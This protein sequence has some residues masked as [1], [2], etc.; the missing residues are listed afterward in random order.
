M[1]KGKKQL[2]FT[3]A[4]LVATVF[5]ISSCGNAEEEVKEKE[6]K[7]ESVPDE[8]LTAA[9]QLEKLAT[10]MPENVEVLLANPFVQVTKFQLAP[11]TT[12]PKL[13]TEGQLIYPITECQL[14]T[15][16]S[17]QQVEWKAGVPLWLKGNATFQNT[18]GDLMSFISI[19]REGEELDT[20]EHDLVPTAGEDI[21]EYVKI[22]LDNEMAII[23]EVSLPS[24]DTTDFFQGFDQLIFTLQENNLAFTSYNGETINKNANEGEAVWLYKCDHSLSNAGDTTSS[25]LAIGFKK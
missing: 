14:S 10:E 13:V 12:V 20:C 6:E 24:G 22:L 25:F 5:M 9:S 11:N 7:V 15:S 18:T 16:E 8:A 21:P 17:G 19:I 1:K 4:F 2:V 23:T 3:I